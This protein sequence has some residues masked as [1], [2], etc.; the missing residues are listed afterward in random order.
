MLINSFQLHSILFVLNISFNI[1]YFLLHIGVVLNLIIY[2][3][4]NQILKRLLVVGGQ[5]L[6][7]S[8]LLNVSHIMT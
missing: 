7:Y 6:C 1:F 8:I 2:K 4:G 5:P 3:G